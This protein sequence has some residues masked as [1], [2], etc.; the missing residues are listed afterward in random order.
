MV[1]ATVRCVAHGKE[2]HDEQRGDEYEQFHESQ[3]LLV[4]CLIHSSMWPREPPGGA[5]IYVFSVRIFDTLRP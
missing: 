5:W 4:G 1:R 3:V 2:S